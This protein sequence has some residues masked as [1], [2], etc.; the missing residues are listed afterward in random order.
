MAEIENKSS[1]LSEESKNDI[2]ELFDELFVKDMNYNVVK[3]TEE[4]KKN[5]E[6]NLTNINTN[7]GTIKNLLSV[8]QGTLDD[9]HKVTGESD[10][11][12]GKNIASLLNDIA[13]ETVTGKTE[14]LDK[15]ES[16]K[17]GLE[18]IKDGVQNTNSAL[19]SEK[20]LITD[21][22]HKCDEIE[23]ALNK[24]SKRIAEYESRVVEY[25]TEVNSL[26]GSLEVLDNSIINVG[27]STEKKIN[28]LYIGI[29]IS[30][31]INIATVLITLFR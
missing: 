26:K 16:M 23:S 31:A 7:I 12:G 14:S 4:V 6:Q 28:Y 29:G 20:E 21:L 11:W 25:N 9:I 17:G 19:E 5:N 2:K 13:K 1:D 3:V 15:I 27:N 18:Q 22:S 30:L 8:V 24:D 10:V